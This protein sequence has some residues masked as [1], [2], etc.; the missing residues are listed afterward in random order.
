MKIGEKIKKYGE[1][2][3]KLRNPEEQQE[4]KETFKTAQRARS[5]KSSFFQELAF[6]SSRWY[7]KG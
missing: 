7:S 5:Q 4:K 3:K 6:L 2:G 1:I